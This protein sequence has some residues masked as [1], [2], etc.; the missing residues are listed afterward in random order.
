MKKQFDLGSQGSYSAFLDDCTKFGRMVLCTLLSDLRRG[1][2]KFARDLCI[3]NIFGELGKKPN[4]F[5]SNCFF[6]VYYV[7][8]K[9]F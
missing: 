5:M 2:K 7:Y 1:V 6:E 8:I 3:L 9:D 4:E